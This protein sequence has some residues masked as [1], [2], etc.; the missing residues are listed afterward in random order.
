M[1]LL[2]AHTDRFAE[3]VGDGDLEAPVT[4]CPGWTV[5]DLV[6][7][8]GGVHQWA[9]HAVLEGT[10]N[11][12]PDPAEPARSEL[13]AWYRR[14]ASNL[15]EVLTERP[16]EAAAWTL[17]DQNPTAGF[18]R[19]RQVHETAMHVWDAEEALGEPR[20]IDPSLAWDGVLEVVDVIYP[21]QVRH[22]RVEPL[23]RAVRL[24]A[25]DMSGDVILGT[26]ESV[27]VRDRAEILLRLL[28]HR[29][30]AQACMVNPRASVLLSAAVTP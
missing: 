16:A 9:A 25:T 5:R 8:L 21:R 2:R 17:D 24:V 13:A 29:A 3:I 6:V 10:P 30:D 19:R 11:L 28:W 18:W 1:T 26:G 14:H 23:S 15:V 20:P 7:H 22:G 4:F 12:R 27:V